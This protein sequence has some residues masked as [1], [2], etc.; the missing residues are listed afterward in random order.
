MVHAAC[1]ALG[2]LANLRWR[3]PL[4]TWATAAV[5]LGALFYG[6]AWTAPELGLVRRLLFALLGIA[7]LALLGR[8]AFRTAAG[9]WARRAFV[10]PLLPAWGNRC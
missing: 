7:T 1:V 3:L 6:L 10:E 8:R 4:L 2:V 5:L 9:E